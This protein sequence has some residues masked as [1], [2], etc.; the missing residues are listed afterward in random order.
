MASIGILG[1]LR[2]AWALRRT[3]QPVPGR[4]GVDVVL[5]FR[6]SE[7]ALELVAERLAGLRLL[8]GDTVTISW[9]PASGNAISVTIDETE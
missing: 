9:T 2:G 8:D 6:G 4:P 5:P 1:G 3:L 7:A